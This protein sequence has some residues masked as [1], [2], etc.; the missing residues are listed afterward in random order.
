MKLNNIIIVLIFALPVLFYLLLNSGMSN[1]SIALG[2]KPAVIMI[3][4][5]MC[6][7]CQKMDAVI[8][9]LSPEF[10]DKVDFTKLYPENKDSQK[11]IKEYKVT[12]TPTFLFFN[13]HGDLKRKIEGS[14]PQESFKK[15]LEELKNE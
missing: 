11:Y 8:K 14:V 4:S 10:S 12:L 13:T 1:K 2:T 6:G 9:N 3:S 15:Y 7:E 5:T